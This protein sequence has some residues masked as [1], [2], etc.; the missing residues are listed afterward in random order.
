LDLFLIQRLIIG[1]A[2]EFTSCPAWT[3]VSDVNEMPDDFDAYNVF[4]YVNSHPMML[5]EPQSADFVGVKI[6]DILGDAQMEGMAPEDEME[7]DERG[8]GTLTFQ[9]T[10]PSL[11]AGEEVTLY[12]TSEEFEDIVSYQFG[13]QFPAEQL[14][15]V[16]FLP[17]T[18]EPFHTVVAGDSQ[19]A[20]GK[21]RLSWF[22]LDGQ[23]H[24]AASDTPLF[25][26]RFRALRSVDDFGAIIR[27]DPGEMR[28]EAYNI[29]EQSLSPQLTFGNDITST[30]GPL[31]A[32]YVL[33]QNVPNPVSGETLISFYLPQATRATVSLRDAF[34]KE[35][36]TQTQ[37]Y[38]AGQQQLKVDAKNLPAGVYHYTL[39][40]DSFRATK[41]LVV[42]R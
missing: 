5:M 24:T 33:Y 28:A 9:S 17:A 1:A 29:A 26:L 14:E 32:E 23:G 13:L 42:V 36:W 4:P 27:I 12:F 39:R 10:N 37:N 41:S 15:F 2:E 6:G 8:D 19:A 16:E 30:H 22:S 35:V 11:A 34:G 20:Q 3:F 38:P 21:L 18:E 40:A 7:V 25:G 31:A